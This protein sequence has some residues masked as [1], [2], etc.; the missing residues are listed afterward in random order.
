MSGL[1]SSLT[2]VSGLLRQDESKP[3][4]NFRCV[5]ATTVCLRRIAALRPRREHGSRL[6]RA[7]RRRRLTHAAGRYD[8]AYGAI[9]TDWTSAP[10]RF[11]LRLTIPANTSAK[12]YLPRLPGTTIR[13]GGQ[14]VSSAI[15]GDSAVVQVASGTYVFDVREPLS[16]APAS[17]F[18]KTRRQVGSPSARRTNAL[19][20][21][22]AKHSER[23]GA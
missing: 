22:L 19:I 2:T 18:W 21:K 23:H 4:R 17:H 3:F 10:D 16:L 20:G 13:E 12:V 9:G 14:R 6:R 11:T 1:T 7:H 8:S 5:D 15:E